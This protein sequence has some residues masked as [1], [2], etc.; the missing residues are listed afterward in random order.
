MDTQM[1]TYM[2]VYNYIECMPAETIILICGFL[3]N[4]GDVTRFSFINKNFYDIIWS[5]SFYKKIKEICLQNTQSRKYTYVMADLLSRQRSDYA[6]EEKIVSLFNYNHNYFAQ[7]KKLFRPIATFGNMF[8][9]VCMFH[10]DTTLQGLLNLYHTDFL[11]K[12]IGELFLAACDG[13]NLS[14]VKYLNDNFNVM[15]EKKDSN[16]FLRSALTLGN[17]EIIEYILDII[18]TKLNHDTARDVGHFVCENKNDD[19]R[20]IELLLKY[21]PEFDHEHNICSFLEATIENGNFSCARFIFSRFPQILTFFADNYSKKPVDDYIDR[22]VCNLFYEACLHL[23]EDFLIFLIEHFPTFDLVDSEGDVETN[24]FVTLC[25][26][27]TVCIAEHKAIPTRS[28]SIKAIKFKMLKLLLDTYPFIPFENYY[29]YG[30]EDVCLSESSGGCSFSIIKLLI[31]R[32]NQ[33]DHTIICHTIFEIFHRRG[34]VCAGKM[35]LKLMDYLEKENIFFLENDAEFYSKIINDIFLW[36]CINYEIDIINKIVG[37]L[38][39]FTYV[40]NRDK[41]ILQIITALCK[42]EKKYICA[43]RKIKKGKKPGKQPSIID[44]IKVLWKYSPGVFVDNCFNIFMLACS[45]QKNDNW[46]IAAILYANLREKINMLIN[47]QGLFDYV[48][49]KGSVKLAWW[50][51]HV[52]KDV[53]PHSASIKKLY[54]NLLTKY[55]QKCCSLPSCNFPRRM[56]TIRR[57]IFQHSFHVNELAQEICKYATADFKWLLFACFQIKIKN[58]LISR[59][60]KISEKKYDTFF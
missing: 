37:K 51:L 15:T 26:M 27:D 13:N 40:K 32:A 58:E 6:I 36:A 33:K 53:V 5:T 12:N 11:E 22:N 59:E 24:T 39:K 20:T 55:S 44:V 54:E 10:T 4:I 21:F 43:N 49:N 34:I 2:M 30:I 17:L 28:I 52:R 18:K 8:E 50:I 42:R 31:E 7:C 41:T 1:D 23:N 46:K 19:P 14:T 35:L 3:E 57:M 9:Y 48:C 25:G 29:I 38:N 56:C 45:G 16:V 47:F 60:I